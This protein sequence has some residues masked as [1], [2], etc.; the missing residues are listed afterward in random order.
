MSMYEG[1]FF[2]INM[3][4]GRHSDFLLGPGRLWARPMWPVGKALRWSL[5]GYY[6]PLVSRHSFHDLLLVSSRFFL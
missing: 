4:S 6:Y 3:A 1:F 2:C 5:T